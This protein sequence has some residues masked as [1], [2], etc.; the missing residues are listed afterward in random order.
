[1]TKEHFVSWMFLL[2]LLTKCD[3]HPD[4]LFSHG[5][6]NDEN[7][8]ADVVSPRRALDLLVAGPAQVSLMVDNSEMNAS[9]V[10]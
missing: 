10:S 3:V 4:F 7:P 9:M 6:A 5:N 1:M 8:S 2:D